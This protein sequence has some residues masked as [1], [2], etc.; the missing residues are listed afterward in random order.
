MKRCCGPFLE[1][2]K[3]A[4]EPEELV[5]SRYS[6]F[7]RSRIGYLMETCHPETRCRFDEQENYLW[8][9][10]SEW[11]GL[12]IIS[13]EVDPGGE[14]AQVE[15]KAHLRQKGLKAVHHEVSDLRRVDD[16][17]Y[18]YDGAPAKS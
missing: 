17:W 2:R 4:S 13:A 16:R 5:R 12:E 10:E 3:Q 9:R 6:A 14:R 18:Y 15:F 8:A 11:T 7:A 1:G